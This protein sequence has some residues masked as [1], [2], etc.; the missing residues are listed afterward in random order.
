MDIAGMKI[1]IDPTLKPDE[2]RL[3]YPPQLEAQL[4]PGGEALEM[5]TERNGDAWVYR[6]R[7]APEFVALRPRA[8]P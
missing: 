7:Y 6:I 8:T 1:F 5:E 4:R 3:T 2:V